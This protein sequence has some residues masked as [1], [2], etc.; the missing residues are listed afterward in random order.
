M[1]PGIQARRH[2]YPDL[3]AA[4]HAQPGAQLRLP[5]RADFNALGYVMAGQG[6][7]GA[8]RRPVRTG[9]L[10]VFGP[11]D[12]LTFGASQRADGPSEGLDVLVLGGQPIREPVAAYGPFVMNT[13]AELVQA[14]EDYQAGQARAPIPASGGHAPGGAAPRP[15]RPL[16][17][18]ARQG[19]G[20]RNRPAKG[21]ARQ[22]LRTGRMP[23]G[24]TRRTGRVPLG[25]GAD[26]QGAARADAPHGQ[27]PHGQGGPRGWSRGE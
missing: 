23:H 6:T 5:W 10:A 19:P 27:A 11:G 15:R 8:E 7:V 20:G 21:G 25:Q 24:Q 14:F 22:V 17:P 16:A 13:R 9:Q 2:A 1:S 18:R 12:T 3:P 26:G 4:R